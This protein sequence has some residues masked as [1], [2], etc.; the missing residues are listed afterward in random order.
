MEIQLHVT[1]PYNGGKVLF[2]TDNNNKFV[3]TYI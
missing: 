3:C 1:L 2:L